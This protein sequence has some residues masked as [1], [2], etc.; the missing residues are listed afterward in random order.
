[1]HQPIYWPYKNIIQ[2]EQN[3]RYPF[4]VIDIHNQRTGPYTSWPK[5]AILKGINA[6]LGNFGAQVS[7][8]DSLIEN[9]NNLESS[10]NINFQN[11][12]NHWN[13]MKN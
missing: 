6:N 11:W 3:N 5:N 12:K 2:T 8:S 4:S 13:F 7:F 10:G 9:L 1:M